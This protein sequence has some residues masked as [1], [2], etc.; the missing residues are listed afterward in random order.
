MPERLAE[1]LHG[2]AVNG[3]GDVVLAM[4]IVQFFH[5][6]QKLGESIL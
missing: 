6:S 3:Y 2:V 4:F 5:A 1:F